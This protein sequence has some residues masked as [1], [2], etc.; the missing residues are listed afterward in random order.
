MFVL[1]VL[2]CS[3]VSLVWRGSERISL[4]TR[5]VTGSEVLYACGVACWRCPGVG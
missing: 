4:V 3:S 1:T 2:M 5:S